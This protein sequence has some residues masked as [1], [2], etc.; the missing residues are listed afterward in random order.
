MKRTFKIVMAIALVAMMLV[1][2]VS[3][4]VVLENCDEHK[5]NDANLWGGSYI[6]AVTAD[7]APEGT[8][9]IT[10]KPAGGTVQIVKGWDPI[11]LSEMTDGYF[12]ID[13]YVDDAASVTG[14][15]LEL[16]SAGADNEE[17]SWEVATLGLVDGWN[18]LVLKVNEAN[19][20]AGGLDYSNFRNFRFYAFTGN[21][22]AIF[23]VDN[24][25]FG[26]ED[27]ITIVVD[28]CDALGEDTGFTGNSIGAEGAYTLGEDGLVYMPDYEADE[29]GNV[30]VAV[31]GAVEDYIK[32][33]KG[34][35]YQWDKATLIINFLTDTP[36]DL[37][38][39]ADDGYLMF[40]IYFSDGYGT[41][42]GGQIELTS[43]HASDVEEISWSM[44]ELSYIETGWN[45][46]ALSLETASTWM[47][48]ADLSQIDTFR[49]YDFVVAGEPVEIR[50]DNICFGTKAEAIELGYL[51]A[52]E[53]V[54]ETEEV[55]E[56]VTEE[57]TE[58]V[59][60]EVTEEA[61]EEV[62]EEATEEATEGTDAPAV[63]E[64]GSNMGLII[65]IIA[66]VAVVVIVVI[67]VVAKKKK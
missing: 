13:I 56:E 65:G 48:D 16:C 34:S 55:T 36:Y 2:N 30:L 11:D 4:L 7:D 28:N 37:S 67:V 33:G 49:I 66:V 63:E 59:T 50:I 21:A 64:E 41:S 62:T 61:T 45:K 29:D 47:D 57:A 25:G 46:V 23:G 8:G 22:D 51:A 19:I 3:A 5:Y 27:E 20:V 42:L 53:E 40:D 52:E 9:Y 32:E 18:K 35:L 54:E 14:G 26:T 31:E 60:E 58:E 24:L 44:A 10:G 43:G 15:Q 39:Y 1:S 38:A 17:N 12:H 6:E